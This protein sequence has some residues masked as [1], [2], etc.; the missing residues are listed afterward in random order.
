MGR[1]GDWEKEE[2][3]PI[4]QHPIFNTQVEEKQQRQDKRRT[5]EVAKIWRAREVLV[6]FGFAFAVSSLG[7]WML[8]VG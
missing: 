7:N 8:S 5:T 3:I 6:P 4:T 2:E 1:L